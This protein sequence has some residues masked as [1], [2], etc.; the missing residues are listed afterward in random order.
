MEKTPHVLLL[1]RSC[2]A[3]CCGSLGKGSFF[4]GSLVLMMARLCFWELELY[5]YPYAYFPAPPPSHGV[6]SG[7]IVIIKFLC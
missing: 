2:R 5:F 7:G 1:R 3:K 6:K 4:L